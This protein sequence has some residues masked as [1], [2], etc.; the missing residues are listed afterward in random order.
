MGGS[1]YIVDGVYIFM[2]QVYHYPVI[3]K[4]AWRCPSVAVSGPVGS[5]GTQ[6]Q[7]SISPDLVHTANNDDAQLKSII[8]FDTR[9]P[10]DY[11]LLRHDINSQ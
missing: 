4:W 8:L 5:N 11:K 3:N 6:P 9:K 2:G 1:L 10:L 7:V